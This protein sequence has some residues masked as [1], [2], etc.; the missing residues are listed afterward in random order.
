MIDFLLLFALRIIDMGLFTVR[1]MLTMRG[2][3]AA[4]WLFAFGGSLAFVIGVRS[5]LTGETSWPRLLGYAAGFA[6]GML[7]GMW[8]EERLAIGYTQ[9][10]IVSPRR[11]A[12][13]VEHLR[14]AGYAVT[15]IS[16]RGRDS[17][18][19]L[20]RCSVPRRK[21]ADLEHLA[22][23]QDPEA[24]ITAQDVRPLQRGYW[25]NH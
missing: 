6:T 4:A 14:A 11:G 19:D 18:I 13:I 15:E 2:R 22:L 20:L 9:V 3:R 12:V 16:G 23:Q 10:Q 25:P 7:A 21:A 8:L 24:F 17:S 1:F 5:V